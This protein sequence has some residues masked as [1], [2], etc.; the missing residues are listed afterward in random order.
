METFEFIN[1]VEACGLVE[2]GHN[3]QPYAWCNHNEEVARIWKRLNRGLVN[4]KLLEKMPQTNSPSSS[5]SR[6]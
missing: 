1:I 4:D 5:L 3:G 6:I 2:I